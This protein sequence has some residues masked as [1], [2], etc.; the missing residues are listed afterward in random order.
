MFFKRC[1]L[2]SSVPIRI[3]QSSYYP[4]FLKKKFPSLV[5]PSGQTTKKYVEIWSWD[6]E[7]G[8]QII[9]LGKTWSQD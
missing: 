4:Y 1:M 7:N 9:F 3:L 6:V 2:Q 8:E 5:P